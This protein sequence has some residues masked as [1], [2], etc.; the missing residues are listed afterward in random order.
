MHLLLQLLTVFS[1]LKENE[2]NSFPAATASAVGA[3]STVSTAT[4]PS[5][6]SELGNTVDKLLRFISLYLRTASRIMLVGPGERAPLQEPEQHPGSH[7]FLTL[8]RPPFF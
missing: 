3:N 6:E 7:S 8:A 2:S 5:E 4:A 1:P